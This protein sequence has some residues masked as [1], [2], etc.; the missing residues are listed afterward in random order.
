MPKKPA[1]RPER[2]S[3]ADVVDHLL[4][5]LPGADP[6]LRGDPGS[7]PPPRPPQP[8][9]GAP[10]PPRGLPGTPASTGPSARDVGVA[11]LLVIGGV[12]FGAAMTQWPYASVCGFALYAYL[13][14]VF[15]VLLVGG[16]AAI[17]T[18]RC[19]IPSAH[20][21]ALVL[22]FWGVV[23]AAEQVLPRMGYAQESATWSCTE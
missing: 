6:S 19:R 12:G 2:D 10:V 22:V 11:W 16:W 23:L 15:V 21:V 1:E 8:G 17:L 13:A 5:K 14:A 18:W 4:K 3:F 9:P 20:V 7:G